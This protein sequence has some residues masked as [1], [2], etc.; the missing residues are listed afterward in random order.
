MNSCSIDFWISEIGSKTVK[1]YFR[2]LSEEE[3]VRSNKFRFQKDKHEFITS[4]GFLRTVLASYIQKKP[5]EIKFE[6]SSFGKPSIKDNVHNL[7]FNLSHSNGY[8]VIAITESDEIGVDLEFIKSFDDLDKVAKDVFTKNELTILAGNASV[9]IELF[10]K[11]WT[12]KESMIKALG[13]GLLIPLNQVDVSDLN[14]LSYSDSSEHISKKK[15]NFFIQDL[16]VPG[17]FAGAVAILGK[18]KK[19][20]YC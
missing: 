19:I 18:K 9:K 17:G 15:N 12:R 3:K 4:R 2:L 10:F 16:N 7:K 11:F 13:K 14:T 6:Y 5:E 1:N 8:A 20:N